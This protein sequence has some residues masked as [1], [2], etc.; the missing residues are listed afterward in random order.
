MHEREA[1]RDLDQKKALED[2]IRSVANSRD[3]TPQSPQP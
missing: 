2:Y 3:D 1:K